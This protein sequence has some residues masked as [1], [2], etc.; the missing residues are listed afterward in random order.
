MLYQRY[1]LKMN[2]SNMTNIIS[3]LVL[4]CIAFVVLAG[5][6]MVFVHDTSAHTF[7][8]YN[9]NLTDQATQIDKLLVLICTT[10]C[11]IAIY[12]GEYIRVRVWITRHSQIPA[13]MYYVFTIII[14]L[15]E[16]CRKLIIRFPTLSGRVD[17][18]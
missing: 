8:V 15:Y 10:G 1:F 16:S 7:T 2:Q 6:E 14:V 3:L 13:R 17:I 11:C 9:G 18:R 4:V 12:S 5:S